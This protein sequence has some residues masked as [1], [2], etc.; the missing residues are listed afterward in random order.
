MT[1]VNTETG[2]IDSPVLNYEIHPVAD[3]FPFIEGD[4][5]REFVE[6]IRVNGQREPVVLDAD[7][8]LLDGRNRARACQALGIDVK[9][10]RYSGD[11]VEAW[12]ISH[13]VHRRHLTE[14]QRAMVA[15]KLANLR[16][17]RPKE[18][19][20]IGGVSSSNTVADAASA[21]NVGTTS[22][23]RAK[24]VLRSGDAGLIKAVESGEIT[25]NK[26]ERKVRETK[27]PKVK[28]AAEE[29]VKQISDL[30]ERGATSGQIAKEIGVGEK[31]VRE[32]ARKHGVLIVADEVRGKVRRLNHDVI[33]ANAVEAVEVASMALRDID[34]SQIDNKD[35]ALDGLDSLTKS[36]TALTKAIKTIKESLHD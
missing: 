9:E 34:P 13:N 26:A 7:G 1:A 30:A 32:L 23:D 22:V 2:E 20:P 19:P 31:Q 6:D 18:T 4:A 36:I 11:D 24:R 27:A 12:I 29:R 21:L 10:T 16:P 5:F 15:A 14:S 35:E 28:L 8:R 3:L 33:L 17:G 25:V